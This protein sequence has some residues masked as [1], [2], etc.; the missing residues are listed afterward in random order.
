[1]DEVEETFN[2]ATGVARRYYGNYGTIPK[3][4]QMQIS[5]VAQIIK[6]TTE[7]WTASLNNQSTLKEKVQTYLDKA[8]YANMLKILGFRDYGGR[9]E[10]ES[11][12]HTKFIK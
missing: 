1:M 7:E 11:N 4:P 2:A 8:L 9:L 3:L 6:E 12:S 10:L 5:E